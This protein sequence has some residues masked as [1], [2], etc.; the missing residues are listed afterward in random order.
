M[1]ICGTRKQIEKR[2]NK[3][4]IIIILTFIFFQDYEWKKK[5][6]HKLEQNKNKKKEKSTN[7]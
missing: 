3:Y 5:P 4:A 1:Q 6:M 2:M 7:L